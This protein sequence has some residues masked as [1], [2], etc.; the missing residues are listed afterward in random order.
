M[1][2]NHK[3]HQTISFAFIYKGKG[4]YWTQYRLGNYEK[5]RGKKGTHFF[6]SSNLTSFRYFGRE[7]D[8]CDLCCWFLKFHERE[9]E[10]YKKEEDGGREGERERERERGVGR[11][12]ML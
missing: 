9:K 1:V 8:E 4:L 5:K 12:R 11:E 2:K 6:K 10:R 7:I 3:R